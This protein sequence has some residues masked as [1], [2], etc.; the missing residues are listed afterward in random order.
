MKLLRLFAF[1][2]AAC[3]G[4][5][6]CA[7]LPF[8]PEK[9]LVATP[10]DR[11]LAWED[12]H[13]PT[14]DGLILNGWYLPAPEAGGTDRPGRGFTLL[15]FH[16]NAGNISHRLESLRIF[17][18]LGLNVL[19][20]DYRGFGKS[21][22]RVSVNG[23]RIDALA[24][25]DWLEQQKGLTPE[26]IVLFGR[27]LGGAVAASLAEQTKPAGLIIESS[28]TSLY[29]VGSFLFPHLPVRWFLPQ[30]YD[31]VAS[32][33]GKQIPLLVVHSPEDTLV[34]YKLGR[35]LYDS[36]QGPK[37]FLEIHGSH[38]QGFYQSLDTYLPGLAAFLRG[39]PRPAP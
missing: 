32:L 6:G 29:D 28:F 8:S 2:L 26:R 23:T 4:L 11:G 18:G 35:A 14:P 13:I 37:T 30:D 33:K 17:H 15:F 24:A 27:S 31:S 21:E 9:K 34:P 3:C 25:W 16:G 10:S 5:G 12:A 20:I 38:N 19:I 22:G 1:A 39:L 36:Y 7:S